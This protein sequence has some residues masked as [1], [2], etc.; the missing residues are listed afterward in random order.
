MMIA[1]L[2]E[3]AVKKTLDQY[4]KNDKKISKTTLGGQLVWHVPPGRSLFVES[5]NKNAQTYEAIAV[6]DRVLYLAGSYEG[7][8]RYLATEAADQKAKARL[9]SADKASLATA[10]ETIGFRSLSLGEDA[11]RLPLKPKKD[12]KKMNRA[13]RR[14]CAGF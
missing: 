11:W 7:F 4:Y 8:L 5:K 12:T 1:C 9:T 3:A 6:I 2:D 14:C 10:G 13:M